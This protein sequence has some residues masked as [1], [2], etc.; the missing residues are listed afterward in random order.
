MK[1]PIC[2]R[3]FE[4]KDAESSLPFCSDRCKTIDLG[5]WLD[6]KYPFLSDKDEEDDQQIGEGWETDE[7]H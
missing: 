5:R 6:E 2:G 4:P 3:E 7:N 1:C